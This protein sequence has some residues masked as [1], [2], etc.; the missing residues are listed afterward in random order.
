MSFL[1]AALRQLH[2]TR[3]ALP[4]VLATGYVDGE[5]TA[6]LKDLP[7]ILLL[8]KPYSASE[9]EKIIQASQPERA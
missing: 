7:G 8:S 2:A 5:V 9:L 1:N 3:A 4:L 6:L